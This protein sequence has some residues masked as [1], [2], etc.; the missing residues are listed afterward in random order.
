MRTFWL[1]LVGVGLAVVG[2]TAVAAAAPRE[3]QRVDTRY[4]EMR[5][6]HAAPGKMEALHA[7]FR[8][9]TCKLFAKHGITVIGF[10]NPAD[11]KEAERT[12]I[13]LLAYPSP[14]ARAKSWEAFQ[15]DPE[16]KAVKAESEK[17]G[18]LVDRIDSV[19]LQ[20]TD[21]SPIK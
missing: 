11:R 2:V 17:D 5:T 6:Y 10:W 21:Y 14:E 9:H 7:R 16:W 3:E 15:N 20:P 8:D 1:S 13:Y 4:F 18:K 19:F 12:L